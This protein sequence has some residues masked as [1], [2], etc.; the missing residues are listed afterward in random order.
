MPRAPFGYPI[1]PT[2]QMT[3]ILR[4]RVQGRSALGR[5]GPCA[6]KSLT[7]A[8]MCCG[9]ILTLRR[10]RWDAARFVEDMQRSVV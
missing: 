1:M 10:Q 2:P 3:E 4:T 5:E 7:R 8:S 9:G 6:R